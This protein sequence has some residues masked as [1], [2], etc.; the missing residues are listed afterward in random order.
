MG[1]K[2][3]ELEVE[4]HVVDAKIEAKVESSLKASPK[5]IENY[6]EILKSGKRLDTTKYA[7]LVAT[8]KS[9]G[10]MKKPYGIEETL[11]LAQEVYSK[12]K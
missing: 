10:I 11:A 8:A 2:D 7:N 3:E 1:N 12:L 5:T 6:V 4:E 9:H